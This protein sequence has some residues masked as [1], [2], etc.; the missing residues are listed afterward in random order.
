MQNWEVG[1]GRDGNNCLYLPPGAECYV[2]VPVASLGFMGDANHTTPGGGGISFAVWINADTTANNMRSSW[3]GLFSVWNG[4]LS[5]ETLVA[6]CPSPFPPTAPTGPGTIF[7]KTLPSATALAFNMQESDYGGKWNHWAFTK[8][9]NEMKI[10]CNGMA[11][12]DINTTDDAD[13][14]GPLFD[15]VVGAFRIGTR[16]GN[17]GMWNG[18]IDDFQ[19]YDY[20]LSA[21]EVAYLVTD[22]EGYVFLPLDSP[23]NINADGGLPTDANQIVNFGDLAIMCNQW[24]TQILWP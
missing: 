17:W 18:Y 24:H 13:V 10:Y 12:A 7:M 20:C 8:S 23:A 9:A 4:T 3:N 21:E 16:G 5:M 6:H 11:V 22:G 14:Y 1:G 19:V 2:N 15:K